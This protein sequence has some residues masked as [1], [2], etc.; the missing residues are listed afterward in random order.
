MT[1]SPASVDLVLLDH[2]K[3]LYE[4][5]LLVLCRKGIVKPG[6]V[7][8]LHDVLSGAAKA[9]RNCY[10]LVRTF[11]LA[12]DLRTD[13]PA[14]LAILRIPRGASPRRLRVMRSNAITAGRAAIDDAILHA[15]H[16]VGRGLR[17]VGLRGS[18]LS[19]S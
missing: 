10:D 18:G 8:L 4:R 6:G 13:V 1:L 17:R 7:I 14:G 9:W 16:T 11:D 12:V 2:F 15:R 19:H 3:L 5:D